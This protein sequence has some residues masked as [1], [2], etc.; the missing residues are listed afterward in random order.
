[1]VDDPVQDDSELGYLSPRA[2]AALVVGYTAAGMVLGAIM[3]P[4]EWGLASQV[5]LGGMGGLGSMLCVY[6]ARFLY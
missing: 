2:R 1:M 3:L 5:V 6:I 4:P